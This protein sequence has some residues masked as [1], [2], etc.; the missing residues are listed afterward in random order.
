MTEAETVA[1]F[2]AWL[3]REGWL[4]GPGADKWLDVYAT[5]DGE[6]LCAEA[7]GVTKDNGV[8]AD[9]LW[10]QILR[11]MTELDAPGVRYA[12]VLPESIKS[13]VLRVPRVARAG[14]RS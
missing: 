4:V 3:E 11:R 8:S 14:L 2:T 1:A 6:R 13:Q 5:R 12:L 7:K 9:I 10:G